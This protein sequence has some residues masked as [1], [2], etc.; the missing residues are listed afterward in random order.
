VNYRRPAPRGHR[1]WL[2]LTSDASLEKLAPE[3]AA[4]PLEG[5]AAGDAQTSA[6]GTPRVPPPYANIA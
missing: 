1:T 4:T 2:F 5:T 6:G 3:Q